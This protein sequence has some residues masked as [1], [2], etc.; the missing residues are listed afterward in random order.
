[1]KIEIEIEINIANNIMKEKERYS[2][3]NICLLY[4]LCKLSMYWINAVIDASDLVYTLE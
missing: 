3:F 4:L 1:M 2:I